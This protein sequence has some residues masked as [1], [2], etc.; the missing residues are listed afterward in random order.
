MFKDQALEK[1]PEGSLLV[2]GLYTSIK[3]T[4]AFGI[5]KDVKQETL[6]GNFLSPFCKSSRQRVMDGSGRACSFSI[7]G[8][9]EVG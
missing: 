7:L 2:L 5:G 6:W 3:T 9:L 4:I 8:H 1:I